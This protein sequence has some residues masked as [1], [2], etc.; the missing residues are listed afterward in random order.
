MQIKILTDILA[1]L[2][3]SVLLAGKHTEG[4]GTEVVTLRA[5]QYQRMYSAVKIRT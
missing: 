2:E 3:L 1:S 4:V 5:Y